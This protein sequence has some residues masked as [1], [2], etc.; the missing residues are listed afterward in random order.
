MTNFLFKKTLNQKKKK[1]NG[2]VFK[3]L[4]TSSISTMEQFKLFLGL[5]KMHSLNKKTQDMHDG[6][7]HK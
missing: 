6:I 7:E 5:C 1:T 3:C 2:N 4:L